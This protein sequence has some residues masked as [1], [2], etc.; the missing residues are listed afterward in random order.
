MLG[1]LSSLER[2]AGDTSAQL[3]S[4][5]SGGDLMELERRLAGLQRQTDAASEGIKGLTSSTYKRVDEHASAIQ[6]LTLVGR[7]GGREREGGL[8]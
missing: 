4:R 1:R 8:L 6:R 2:L 3:S 5:A 7:G